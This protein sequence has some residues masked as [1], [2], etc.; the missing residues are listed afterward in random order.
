[1]AA[2]KVNDRS[3][4]QSRPARA[5]KTRAEAHRVSGASVSGLMDLQENAEK[6]G[7]RPSWI[8]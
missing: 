2:G 3:S 7:L 5:H 1:M 4:R 8:G 6:F